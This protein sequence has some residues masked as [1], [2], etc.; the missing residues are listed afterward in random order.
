MSNP[1]LDIETMLNQPIPRSV[2]KERD[3]GG[4]RKL[5]YLEGQYVINRL[6]LVFGP[7]YWATDIKSLDC[8]YQGVIKDR[9]DK[10]VFTCHYVAKVRLVVQCEGGPAT[11]HTDVGYG[12][13]TDKGNPGKAH[14]LAVKEAVTDAIKRCA[15]N[16]GLSMGLALYDKDQTNIEEDLLE[17]KQETAQVSSL[18]VSKEDDGSS[19]RKLISSRSRVVVAKNKATLEGLKAEMASK[20]GTDDKNKLTPPQAKEFADHLQSLINS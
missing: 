8:V 13:G 9:Y 3:G 15:K 6:N 11:E 12:D 18:P 16:L 20:Y 7:L 19:S 14:E 1:L 5:S 2:I 17:E 10:N 4:G